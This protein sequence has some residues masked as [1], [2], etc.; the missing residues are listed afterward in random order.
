MTAITYTSRPA[1]GT[2]ARLAWDL[3]VRQHKRCPES[4]MYAPNHEYVS[5]GWICEHYISDP[6]IKHMGYS[7]SSHYVFYSSQLLK[8]KKE[9]IESIPYCEPKPHTA[10]VPEPEPTKEEI[11]HYVELNR[12]LTERIKQLY[13]QNVRLGDARDQALSELG[14]SSIPEYLIANGCNVVS[15]SSPNDPT[16]FSYR[17]PE[18]KNDQ[19]T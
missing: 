19:A 7:G 10:F 12:K 14:F 16:G 5:K 15:S 9:E 18:T 6:L 2:T 8:S 11:Q 4:V 17:K 1:K 3:Y 13:Q